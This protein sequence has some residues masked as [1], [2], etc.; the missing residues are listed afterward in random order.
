M[1]SS[2]VANA[3]GLIF[4]ILSLGCACSLARYPS[5]PLVGVALGTALGLV[6]INLSA[7][8]IAFLSYVVPFGQ[9]DFWL[10]SFIT[11]LFG[12]EL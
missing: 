6:L 5:R 4:G 1:T 7:A 11:R 2:I 9:I 12:I 8:I 10:A 3:L